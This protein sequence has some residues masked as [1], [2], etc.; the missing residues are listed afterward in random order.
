MQRELHYFAQNSQTRSHRKGDDCN[1]LDCHDG[2]LYSAM[3][4]SPY[5]K[6]RL[7]INPTLKVIESVL[8]DAR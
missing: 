1:G 4:H 5:N 2:D 7:S 8:L 6:E 3:P